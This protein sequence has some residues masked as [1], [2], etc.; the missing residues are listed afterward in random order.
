M[1]DNPL[2]VTFAARDVLELKDSFR[3]VER[4]ADRLR[5]TIEGEDGQGGIK[6]SVQQ[7]QN[8]Q[9]VDSQMIRLAMWFPAVVSMIAMFISVA[10]I[11]IALTK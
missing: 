1:P 10:A 2:D 6:A 11:I 5:Y 7:I 4:L 9:K 3:K 8:Q